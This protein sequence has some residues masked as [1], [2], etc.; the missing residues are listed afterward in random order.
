MLP[1]TDGTHMGVFSGPD[2][3]F[4]RS[5][6]GILGAVPERVQGAPEHGPVLSLVSQEAN[7]GGCVA[8]LPRHTYDP[9]AALARNGIA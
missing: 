8:T 7:E 1:S 4:D 9:Y 6:G 2:G 5:E 3:R